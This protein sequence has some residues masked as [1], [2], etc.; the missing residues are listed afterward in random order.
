MFVYYGFETT[1]H[2]LQNEQY[3]VKHNF[4]IKVAENPYSFF[5]IYKYYLEIFQSNT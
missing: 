4:R 2:V 3:I 1:K 5:L